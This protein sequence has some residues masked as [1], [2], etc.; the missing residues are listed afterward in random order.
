[1]SCSPQWNTASFLLGLLNH[2]D[3]HGTIVHNIGSYLLWHGTTSHKTSIFSNTVW[4]VRSSPHGLYEQIQAVT[5]TY[6]H[7]QYVSNVPLSE[8]LPWNWFSVI[9]VCTIARPTLQIGKYNIQDNL[10]LMNMFAE[11]RKYNDLQRQ[12]GIIMVIFWVLIPYGSV[13]WHIS[14]E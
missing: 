6:V 10:L 7:T 3:K 13:G 12:I 9:L 2:E 4:L 5:S 11:C 14:K 8:Q 1:M